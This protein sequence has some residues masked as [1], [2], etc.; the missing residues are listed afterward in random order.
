MNRLFRILL[1]VAVLWPG[2]SQASLTRAYLGVTVQDSSSTTVALTVDSTGYTNLVCWVK[3][4]GAPTTVTATDNKGSGS[5]TGLTK[6][7]HTNGGLSGRILWAT[8]GTPG[9]SHTVTVT[10]GAARDFSRLI[11]WGV[12]STSGT[13]ALDAEADAQ[14]IGG[15]AVDAGSLATTTATVSFMGT[16]EYDVVTYTPG[17]GWTED[18]DNFSH[19]QSRADASGTLDPTCTAS[20]GMDWVANAASFKEAAAAAGNAPGVLLMGV[21]K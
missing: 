13:I 3:H 6:R 21:G 11:C 9:S 17:A 5:Y 20:G 10:F 15:T 1:L 12:N 8:I 18:V 19:G 4:E 7:D 2:A 14:G 16:G